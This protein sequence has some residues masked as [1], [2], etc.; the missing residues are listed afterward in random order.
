MKRVLQ[1]CFLV[2]LLAPVLASAQM[3]PGGERILSYDSEIT[4]MEDGSIHVT[5]NIR[6]RALG[7]QIRH[8][9]YR[10]FPTR[11][12]DKLG[13][14]YTVPFDIV[15]VRRDNQPEDYHTE[16]LLNGTRVYMGSRWA[17][18]IPSEY[19][20]SL[21]YVT[22]R[23]MGFYSDREELYWNVTGNGWAFPIDHAT[24]TVVLPLQIPRNFV[25]TY[26][27]TGPKGYTGRDF[28]AIKD[29]LG[30][31]HYETR[32]PL[33]VHEGF[34]VVAWW[35]RGYIQPPTDKLEY[36]FADNAP[37]VAAVI[38]LVLV[39]LYQ[40]ITWI[41]VGRDPA[42]GTIVPQYIP[43]DGF[44]AA[45]VRE[46]VKMGFDNRAFAAEILG[47]AAKKYLSIEQDETGQYTLV[48]SSNPAAESALTAEERLVARRLFTTNDRLLLTPLNRESLSEAMK[49]LKTSLSTRM[50]RI[51]FVR[52]AGYMAPSVVLT[53]LSFL[54]IAYYADS[55]LKPVALFMMFWLGFWTL[56]V[57]ALSMRVVSVW[58]SALHGGGQQALK[59]GGAIFITLFALPFLAGE[60]FG[61][62]MLVHATSVLCVSVFALLIACNFIYHELLKAPTH[63]GRELLDKIQGFKMFLAATEED[64]LKR[65]GPVNW[66]LDTFNRLLPYA[67]ALDVEQQWS[68]KFAH[69]LAS[70]LVPVG[71]GASSD[72]TTRLL[73]AEVAGGSAAGFASGIGDALTSAISSAATPPGSSSGSSGG[74]SSG[75]GG[76]GGGGGGW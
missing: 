19:T 61:I 52:N 46:M 33:G 44:S 6:V 22:S 35:P 26:G 67:V 27:Y 11:Y 62:G 60:L 9:I 53:I 49:A 56:G 47:L 72:A 4:L 18:L 42:A 10:D 43:P 74:G 71:A 57:A 17:T 51:Y 48:K 2:F 23:Q 15:E 50:E 39:L 68:A 14:R 65:L 3:V 64:Q 58:R 25:E 31:L 37:A 75:G 32:A 63:M 40:V 29:G 8:G 59:F 5:E 73:A 38:G 76:G 30:R 21:S 45:A 12:T 24:A 20:Y 7:V 55:Q 1:F 13:N 36:F 70:T 41:M 34:T 66:N 16:R 54:A 28:Y 69:V